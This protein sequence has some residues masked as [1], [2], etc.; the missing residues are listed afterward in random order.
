MLRIFHLLGNTG[1]QLV[2]RNTW[3][4]GAWCHG[5]RAEAVFGARGFQSI[6]FYVDFY[7]AAMEILCFYSSPVRKEK[8]LNLNETDTFGR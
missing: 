8:Y 2:V 6:D 4:L 7:V 5:L 3:L 1:F